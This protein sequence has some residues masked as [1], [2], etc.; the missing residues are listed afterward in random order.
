MTIPNVSMVD[1]QRRAAGRKQL[2][3]EYAGSTRELVCGGVG[4][5]STAVETSERTGYLAPAPWFRK[6][7]P[8][9]ESSCHFR[10]YVD[11]SL[12]VGCV[13]NRRPGGLRAPIGHIPGENGRFVPDE[14]VPVTIRVRPEFVT[15][16]GAYR[17]AQR[18]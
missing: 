17:R 13:C 7:V 4:P 12:V 16:A 15:S 5:K 9:P 3:V 1:V 6:A 11:P 18:N 14:T 2:T 10:P 8:L